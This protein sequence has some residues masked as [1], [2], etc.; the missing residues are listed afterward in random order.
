M[1]KLLRLKSHL[2]ERGLLTVV[3]DELPFEVKRT[4]YIQQVPTR[5]IV[6]GGHRHKTTSQGLVCIVGSCEIYSNDGNREET[7]L[8]D[9]P[10]KCLL[11]GPNDWHTMQ[12]FSEDAVLLVF[13]SSKYDVSDYIDEPY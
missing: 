9:D 7:F 6:R 2:D 12:K 13:A 8:L 3:Q 4:Y 10:A 5:E 1:A 11:I